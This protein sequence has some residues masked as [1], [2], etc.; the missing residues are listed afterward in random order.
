MRFDEAS[1]PLAAL[2]LPLL[3]CRCP[4]GERHLAPPPAEREPS[5]LAPL[6]FRPAADGG[7]PHSGAVSRC[8]QP[9]PIPG[10]RVVPQIESRILLEFP[11]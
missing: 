10:S 2:P 8:I 6:R 1:P 7:R 4:P 3:P 11:R 5:R 9:R